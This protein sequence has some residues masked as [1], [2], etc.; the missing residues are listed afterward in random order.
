MTF[1]KGPDKPTCT[2]RPQGD[3]FGMLLQRVFSR[4]W[5]PLSCKDLRSF[6]RDH[7]VAD[8]QNTLRKP[9][10]QDCPGFLQLLVSLLHLTLRSNEAWA[11]ETLFAHGS[12]SVSWVLG[13]S[14]WLYSGSGFAW[15]RS[16]AEQLPLDAHPQELPSLQGALCKAVLAEPVIHSKGLG[17][18]TPA[19]I[20]ARPIVELLLRALSAG[21][22]RSVPKLNSKAPSSR[23]FSVLELPL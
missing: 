14:L 21:T 10:Y 4:S 15:K 19:K 12:G 5:L 2:Q 22:S 17:P 11:S 13:C 16:L 9:A 20:K 7:R 3:A 1:R 23:P 8:L 6:P 18:L